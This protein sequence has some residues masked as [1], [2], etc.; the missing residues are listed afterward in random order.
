MAKLRHTYI[1]G[2]GFSFPLGGPLF[3]DLLSRHRDWLLKPTKDHLEKNDH[4]SYQLLQA[5]LDKIDSIRGIFQ[6]NDI[7]KSK[8]NVE[9]L[10]EIICDAEDSEIDSYRGMIE[11]MFYGTMPRETATVSRVCSW[12]KAR[13]SLETY[14]F[15][16][17]VPE[18]SERWLPYKKWFDSLDGRSDS[19]ISMNYDV[20]CEMLADMT[21]NPYSQDLNATEVLVESGRRVPGNS[22]DLLTQSNHRGVPSLF[23]LHGSSD[24]VQNSSGKSYIRSGNPDLFKQMSE[25]IYLIGTPGCNKMKIATDTLQELWQRAMK[26][27]SDSDMVS[28]VGYSLPASD[29]YAKQ[30]ILEAL[31]A[32]PE[33]GSKFRIVSIV[34]GTSQQSSVDANRIYHLLRQSL[35]DSVGFKTIPIIQP[36][37]AQDYLPLIMPKSL[38]EA[39]DMAKVCLSTPNDMHSTISLM[40]GRLK[41]HE[42]R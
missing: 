14:W 30:K 24:W 9:Q 7:A 23:K 1:L 12:I 27:I 37:F 31:S 36:M 29:N 41:R 35:P 21:N 3:N 22:I 32:P 38:G 11:E 17:H 8:L 20:V 6:S 34:L 16:K 10:L 25:R 26:S 40:E 42:S 4:D 28:I 2:A 19:I 13:L 33:S 18:N 15:P 5:I 39:L